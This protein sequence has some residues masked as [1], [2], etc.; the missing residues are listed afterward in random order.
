MIKA[1]ILPNFLWVEV[2]ATFAYLLNKCSTKSMKGMAPQKACSGRN[3][4]V[5]LLKCLDAL[6]ISYSQ[7]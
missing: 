1:K 2:V 3:P 7:G 5:A 4:S 6:H